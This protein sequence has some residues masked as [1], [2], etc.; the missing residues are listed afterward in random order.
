MEHCLG[1]LFVQ[2]TGGVFRSLLQNS[3]PWPTS[4]CEGVTDATRTRALR[5][6]NP[7]MP[8]SRGCCMLQDR[9]DKQ[10]PLLSRRVET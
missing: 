2:V 10:I 9:L 5:S 3:H 1:P 6:Y 4:L 8:V 7:L